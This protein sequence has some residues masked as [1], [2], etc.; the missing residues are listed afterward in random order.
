M[1]A[2]SEPRER[3]RE[4]RV[5]VFEVAAAGREVVVSLSSLG[6]SLTLGAD[7]ARGL[8]RALDA[9]VAESVV[10]AARESWRRVVEAGGSDWGAA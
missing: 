5:Q 6:L 2:P 1:G 8:A 7:D 9:A 3:V 4:L 10:S